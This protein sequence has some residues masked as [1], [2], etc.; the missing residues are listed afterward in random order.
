[1]NG[2]EIVL[3]WAAKAAGN[4]AVRTATPSAW[5][6]LRRRFRRSAKVAVLGMPGVG[7]TA[8]W[9][10]NVR[11]TQWALI[12][13]LLLAQLSVF[14][15]L[16]VPTQR[17][18]RRD[19]RALQGIADLLRETQSSFVAQGLASPFERAQIEIRLARLDLDR[20]RVPGGAPLV[21]T[22]DIGESTSPAKSRG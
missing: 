19:R 13:T 22:G 3:A 12:G 18:L 9:N 20:K 11:P 16:R 17:R 4:A 8:L 1:M 14:G 2:I 7:K 6:W 5:G 15:T 10:G 21:P